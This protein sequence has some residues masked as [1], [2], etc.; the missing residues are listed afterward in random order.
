[1]ARARYSPLARADI[2][3]S[4]AYIA[5]ENPDAARRFQHAV[6]ESIDLLL[7]FPELAPL[8]PHPNRQGLRAKLV[9]GFRNYVL[10]YTVEPDGIY[11][12]RLL[13]SSRD[14]PQA[15]AE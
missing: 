4:A 14:L 5:G 15:L 11:L 12:V 2:D 3:A 10:F 1:M 9:S 13:H 6:R 7:R 8:Y